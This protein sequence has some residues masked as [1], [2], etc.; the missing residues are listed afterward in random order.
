MEVRGAQQMSDEA[1]EITKLPVWHTAKAAYLVIFHN[2]L[3][4]VKLGIVPLVFFFWIILQGY[5]WGGMT[6]A[7]LTATMADNIG[8]IILIYGVS[9]LFYLATI[10]MI[11]AWHRMVILGHADLDSRIRYSIRRNEWSYLWKATLF[12]L[13]ILLIYFLVSMATILAGIVIAVVFPP[14]IQGTSSASIFV[15]MIVVPVL[16]V[17]CGFALRFSLVF[18][19]SA[20]GKPIGFRESWR[21]SRSN[22][23]RL[24]AAVCLGFLPS[25]I[26]PSVANGLLFNFWVFGGDSMVMPTMMDSVLMSAISIPFWL[27][28]L[29]VGVSVW[30]WAYRYLYQDKPITLPGEQESTV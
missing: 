13:L 29:C 18:P 21:K 3:L 26:I 9:C 15:I 10:P 30:S 12:G 4:A 5:F 27:V 25:F 6:V 14:A 22:T 8:V 28:G 24:F 19:A 2:P 23:W 17:V 7:D 20:V 16:L 1:S 11:T